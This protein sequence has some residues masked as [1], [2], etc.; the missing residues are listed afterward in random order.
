M[1]EELEIILE[2]VECVIQGSPVIL[3]VPVLVP[4]LR[5]EHLLITVDTHS[6]MLQC[7]V[8]QY[9]PPILPELQNAINADRT[10]VAGL[11]TELR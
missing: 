7:H 5:A 8:P 4:C 3:S 11:L 1:K 9:D 2:D 10:K 6:G